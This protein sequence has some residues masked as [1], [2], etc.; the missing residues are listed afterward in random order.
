VAAAVDNAA[1]LEHLTLVEA[2]AAEGLSELDLVADAVVVD[3]P[4]T[5]LDRET[6]RLLAE[7][8]RDTIVYVSC[9]PSTLGRD[10]AQLTAA[11]WHHVAAWPVDMFPQTYHI[12]SVNL[13][14]R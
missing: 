5:G 12:E 9:E 7:R 14:R 3:P 13:F 10:A 8:A 1:G 11:G 6:V 2:D 4:R